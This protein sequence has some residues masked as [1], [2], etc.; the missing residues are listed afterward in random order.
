[1]VSVARTFTVGR[2]ADE[3]VAYLADFSNTTEWDPGTVECVRLDDGPVRVGSS[4][5]NTSKV[6]GR[7]TELRYELQTLDAGRLVFVGRNSGAT[8]TDDIAIEPSDGGSV[9]TYR[10]NIQLHGAA[11]LFSPVMKLIFERLANET[12]T[13]MS[14]VLAR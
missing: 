2:A 8:A 3:V 4:W 14:T 5:R 6:A 11:R 7:S 10:A 9:I 12:V 1:M 13:R